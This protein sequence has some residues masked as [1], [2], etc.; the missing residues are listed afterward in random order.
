MRQPTH[1]QREVV[2]AIEK[3]QE[4]N[5]GQVPTIRELGE[6][7]GIASTNGVLDHLRALVLKGYLAHHRGHYVPIKGAWE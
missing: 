1:R 2:D 5:F 7:L 6:I 4:M 3:Y